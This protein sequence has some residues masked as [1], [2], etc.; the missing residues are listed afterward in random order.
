MH[1]YIV[2]LKENDVL[3]LSSVLW[4]SLSVTGITHSYRV[5]APASLGHWHA[6]R[7]AGLTE[8]LPTYPTVVFPLRLLKRSITTMTLLNRQTW[9]FYIINNRFVWDFLLHAMKFIHV[10]VSVIW[11]SFMYSYRC[12]SINLN[13][14]EK[15]IYFSNSTQIVKL[16]YSINSMHTDWSSLSL[17]FF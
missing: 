15:F 4:F 6:V 17:W 12:I 3:T 9:Y 16:V 13:V 8:T 10:F 7:G 5:A 14:V 1:N 11:D 2:F